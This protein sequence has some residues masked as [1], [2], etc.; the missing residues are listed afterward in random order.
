MVVEDASGGDE[1]DEGGPNIFSRLLRERVVFLGGPVS[2]HMSSLLIAQL[3]FLE[4]E[5]PSKAVRLYINSPGGS[6]TAGMAIYD[7]MQYVSCPISTYCLGQAA[8]MGSL[9]LAGGSKGQRMSLPHASIMIH[10]PSWSADGQATDI[11]I[12]AKEILRVR[13]MLTEVYQKH[14]QLPDETAEQA[15]ERFDKALERDYFLTSE[16]A[17]EFGIVDKVLS[18]RPRPGEADKAGEKGKVG[19]DKPAA[20]AESGSNIPRDMH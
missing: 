10:Q 1:G 15:M 14:C 20:P 13:K 18:H 16:E 5:D 8:S 6:V 2:D 7:T 17:L 4:A 19:E 3:L 9:L 12:R 11:A